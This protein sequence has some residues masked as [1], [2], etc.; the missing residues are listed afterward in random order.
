MIVSGFSS[1]ASSAALPRIGA[2]P[3]LDRMPDA[4][5][6]PA[7][8]AASVFVDS[9]STAPADVMPPAPAVQDAAPA[10]PDA[11]GAPPTAPS[12]PTPTTA[13]APAMP[14]MSMRP[15]DVVPNAAS[16][17]ASYIDGHGASR[18]NTSGSAAAAAAAAPPA[19]LQVSSQ[20][21]ARW[22]MQTPDALFLPTRHDDAPPSWEAPPAA[23]SSSS[24]AAP[25]PAYPSAAEEKAALQRNDRAQSMQP[26]SSTQPAYAAEPVYDA[27]PAYV[28]QPTYDAPSAYDAQPAYDAPSAYT[29]PA[30]DYGGPGY[31]AQ[32]AYGYDAPPHAPA[33]Y[34]HDDEKA[35]AQRYYEAQAAV[36]RHQEAQSAAADDEASSSVVSPSFLT[37]SEARAMEEKAKLQ[38]HYA[39]LE[40]DAAAHTGMTLAPFASTHS[41]S[42][43]THSSSAAP[44]RPPKVRPPGY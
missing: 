2:V 26:V 34:G 7:P 21:P 32:P 3:E 25:A 10:T 20:L 40:Q 41:S 6:T 11:W 29:Q 36:A 22:S 14:F 39:Q 12:W 42:T 5:P 43:A 19:S 31:D 9:M 33:P 30:H 13:M 17:R 24:Y 8:P 35:Q 44:P 16:Q 38:S 27:Q 18:P 15:G 23:A 4:E 1:A 37:R 28:G